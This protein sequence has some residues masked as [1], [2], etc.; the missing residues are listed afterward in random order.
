[1]KIP[2]ILIAVEG[3]M[4]TIERIMKA[5]EQG[6]PVIVVKGS[7][8]ASD[9]IAEYLQTDPLVSFFFLKNL[10]TILDYSWTNFTHKNHR[11]GTPINVFNFT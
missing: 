3:G 11:Q 7:G 2:I 5:T 4:H 6:L 10:N 1:M 8:K 9:L